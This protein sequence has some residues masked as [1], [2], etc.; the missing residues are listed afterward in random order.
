[1]QTL[2][3]A[4]KM[5]HS[6]MTMPCAACFSRFRIAM[7]EVQ[8]DPKLRARITKDTG[9]EFTGGIQVD[10]LLTT[11]TDHVGYEA[12][13]KPIVNPLKGLKVACYYGCLLTRPPDHW[14]GALRVPH[15]HGS[16]DGSDGG[17]VGGLGIQD[18]L[19]WR[20]AVSQHP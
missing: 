19:L 18:R 1:M 17:R 13:A 8:N 7:H 20:V 11:I 14:R 10:S 16:A 6:Y 4:Q 3:I 5:G 9:F 12:A 15:E 2:A